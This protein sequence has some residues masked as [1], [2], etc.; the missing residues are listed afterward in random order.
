[1]PQSTNKQQIS[2][3]NEKAVLQKPEHKQQLV[4]P[5]MR[6]GI[7]NK[8]KQRPITRLQKN[9]PKIVDTLEDFK[10]CVNAVLLGISNYV[11]LRFPNADFLSKEKGSHVKKS[12]P[13]SFILRSRYPNLTKMTLPA[14]LDV[15]FQKTVSNFLAKIRYPNQ[16]AN[17][18]LHKTLNDMRRVFYKLSIAND[19]LSEML[20]E[21]DRLLNLEKPLTART[22]DLHLGAWMDKI[23]AP[24][25]KIFDCVER[26]VNTQDSTLTQDL[27]VP[28]NN[29]E[30]FLRLNQPQT[31]ISSKSQST[32]D[33]GLNEADI[34][35]NE[36]VFS[37]TAA[38][39]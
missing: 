35:L 28:K 22:I 39:A 9:P 14:A 18:N 8:T 20:K 16:I 3:L 21:Y 24:G 4:S 27:L 33:I 7:Y 11:D 5:L 36:L 10:A 25:K 37:N 30:S 29:L 12:T 32:A 1:M 6:G 31:K 2:S 26:I 38:A 15:S 23:L 34:G 19:A 13:L 17:Q